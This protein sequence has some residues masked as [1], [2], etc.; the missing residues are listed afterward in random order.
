ME[1]AATLIGIGSL[2]ALAFAVLW[3]KDRSEE[4]LWR[5]RNPPEKLEA[6]RREREQRLL[7]PDWEF[8]AWHLKRPVPGALRALFS[9]RAFLLS[10]ETPRLGDIYIT[11][12]DPL[13]AEG[14]KTMHSWIGSEV[15]SFASCEG[16]PIQSKPGRTSPMRF[17]LPTMMV[18]TEH[19]ALDVT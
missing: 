18:A 10:D 9:D 1:L 8:Y 2:L 4:A 7:N 11:A 3:L 13:D 17:T 16:D 15:I 19:I 6:Q 14:L 5:R 12:F